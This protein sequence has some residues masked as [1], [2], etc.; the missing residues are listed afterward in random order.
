MKHLKK[1][2]SYNYDKL[3]ED[4]KNKIGRPVNINV[5]QATIE[6]FGIR[7]ID[8]TEDY[9]AKSIEDLAEDIFIQLNIVAN[10][11]QRSSSN[12]SQKKISVS[13]YQW[14]ETKLFLQHYP[15][16]LF[17]LVPVFLQILCIIIFRYS[18]WTYLGFNRIQSTAVVL[19]VILGS[20]LTGGFV[21]VIGRLL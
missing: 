16:G 9:G 4:I 7:N 18:L 5:V 20:V 1:N 14:M 11:E 3:F 2:Q 8:I 17:H 13:G 12:V 15:L 10:K 19:G 21:Q 6:S